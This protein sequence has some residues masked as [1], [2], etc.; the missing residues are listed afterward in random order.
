MIHH[1][2]CHELRSSTEHENGRILPGFVGCGEFTN[3]IERMQVTTDA[4]P[5]GHRIL[6]RIFK[7]GTKSTK[8]SDN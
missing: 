1:E 4:V 2:V 3:R 8:G 7:G 5:V 6:H